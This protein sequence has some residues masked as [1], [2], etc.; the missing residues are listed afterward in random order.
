LI[1][2]RSQILLRDS[3]FDLGEPASGCT[4]TVASKPD[5]STALLAPASNKSSSSSAT[6]TVIA[7]LTAAAQKAD[8]SVRVNVRSSSSSSSSSSG[9]MW[10][11]SLG[12]CRPSMLNRMRLRFVALIALMAVVCAGIVKNGLLYQSFGDTSDDS[13]DKRFEVIRIELRFRIAC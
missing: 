11:F 9:S 6:G 5:A 10:C 2:P 8:A 4:P 3:E 13:W 12:S 7:S 1:L